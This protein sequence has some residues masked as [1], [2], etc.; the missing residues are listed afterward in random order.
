MFLETAAELLLGSTATRPRPRQHSSIES[1]AIGDR[2]ESGATSH[3][4][5]RSRRAALR[6][7]HPM[8]LA[9]NS[10]SPAR[11]A[12]V[13]SPAGGGSSQRRHQTARPA[14]TAWAP[15]GEALFGRLRSHV[16]LQ[17]ACHSGN[18]RQSRVRSGSMQYAFIYSVVRFDVAFP[19]M[20][21]N[22]CC[23]PGKTSDSSTGCAV[24]L[25]ASQLAAQ[26]GPVHH[27]H[28]RQ[29]LLPGDSQRSVGLDAGCF[30]SW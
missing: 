25:Q 28:G 24:C 20:K 18:V 3:Q 11:R 30:H 7:P 13:R 10:S 4:M 1:D 16:Y 5:Q 14:W 27:A 19:S 8:P 29:Q 26:G 22:I 6:L 17:P 9:T 23:I 21:S 2:S 12:A 15:M